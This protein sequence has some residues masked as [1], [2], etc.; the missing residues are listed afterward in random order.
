MGL[1]RKNDSSAAKAERELASLRQRRDS[2]QTKLVQAEASLT[3]VIDGRRHVL[4]EG[5]VGEPIPAVVTPMDERD[6]VIDAIAQIEGR[7]RE[8]E[9]RIAETR[10]KASREQEAELRREQIEVAR[11]AADEFTSATERL[12]AALQTLAPINMTTGAASSSVKIFGGQLSAAVTAALVECGGYVARVVAGNAAIV[13]APPP[14]ATTP[15]PAP[16]IE[17]ASVMMLESARWNEADGEVRTVARY[18]IARLPV[19]LAELACARDWGCRTDSERYRRLVESETAPFGQQWARPAP[20]HTR[21]DLDHPDLPPAAELPV[22]T[23][24][25]GPPRQIE[26]TVSR[27]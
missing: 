14:I 15:Q 12:V 20:E 8:A 22:A 19:K 16:E 13:G 25:I 21:I 24:W 6:A 7:I 5:D 11:K 26:I 18:G 27:P 23:E 9:Q 17:R 10:D 2:L 3:R 4:L 1:L